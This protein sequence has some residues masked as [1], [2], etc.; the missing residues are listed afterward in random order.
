MTLDTLFAEAIAEVDSGI[1]S[2]CGTSA[3][4]KQMGGCPRCFAAVMSG[5]DI[6]V[7]SITVY[8]KTGIVRLAL[9]PGCG[10]TQPCEVAFAGV[11]IN[12]R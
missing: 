1:K 5:A 8:R 7:A 6:G 3:P 11:T 4:C 12:I 10:K 2:P 9:S